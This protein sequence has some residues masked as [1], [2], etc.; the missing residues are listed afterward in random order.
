[1][2]T[3]TLA[4][5]GEG[6]QGHWQDN[7]RQRDTYLPQ[8]HAS[9]WLQHRSHAVPAASGDCATGPGG[10]A[11]YVGAEV[12]PIEITL[13]HLVIIFMVPIEPITICIMGLL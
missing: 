2:D 4:K 12:F 11:S 13:Q 5:V 7:Y 8:V 6:L 9:R 1:M 3:A 10:V